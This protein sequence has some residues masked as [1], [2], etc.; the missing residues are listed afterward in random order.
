MMDLREKIRN[1][2]NFP[3]EGVEFKDI[4]TLLKD[5]EAFAYL[6]DQMVEVLK[7]K[8][9]DAILGPEAR[10]FVFGAPVA[11]A[12]KKGFV[13]IRKD[14][15]LPA[16]TVKKTYDLEYGH[17]IVE[18]HKDAIEP[19]MKVVIIDD[20]LATGG[21][22]KATCELVEEMGGQ[23]VGLIFAIELAFLEGR[24]TLAGYDIDTFIVY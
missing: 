2:S 13:P 1:I 18:I 21:T 15:K 6:V 10:G 3:K 9:V 5:G 8:E 22:A 17:N 20:L 4:T 14:G 19:G 16:E 23:V 7:G 11:Y 12:M 24:K